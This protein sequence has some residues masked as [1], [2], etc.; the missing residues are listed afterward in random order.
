[1][2]VSAFFVLVLPA[3]SV[4]VR[5]CPDDLRAEETV[6]E[7][8]PRARADAPRI[9][10]FGTLEQGLAEAERTGRPILLSAASPSC[11]RVPGMW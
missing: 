10:W 11:D 4:P 5:A 3:F 9:Q 2:F 6:Q 7:E 8:T 1:M